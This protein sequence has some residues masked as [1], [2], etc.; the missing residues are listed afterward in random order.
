MTEF[1]FIVTLSNPVQGGLA[2][3]LAE[4]GDQVLLRQSGLEGTRQDAEA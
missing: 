4:P 1:D 2:D 3:R